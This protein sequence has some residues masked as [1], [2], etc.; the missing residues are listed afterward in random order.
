MTKAL[1]L[2][3]LTLF[4]TFYGVAQQRSRKEIRKTAIAD[5]KRFKL[6]QADSLQFKREHRKYRSD[7]LKPTELTTSDPLLLQDS[8]YN[9]VFRSVTFANNTKNRP[10]KYALVVGGVAFLAIVIL[11]MSGNFHL[12]PLTS[13]AK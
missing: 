3:A 9:D 12:E 10:V 11:L 4:T 7:L 6:T 2:V 1:F 8:L 13:T 5:A